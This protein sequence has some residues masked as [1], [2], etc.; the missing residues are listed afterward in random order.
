MIL[1]DCTQNEAEW[2]RL[3][4]GK[5]T[6]S[7]ADEILTPLFA[8]KTG[9]GP[10]TFLY[11]KVAEAYHGLPVAQFTSRAT[12][13]GHDLEDEARKWFLYLHDQHRMKTVGFCE[14][15]GKPCGCS[16]DALLD[17]DGGLEIKAPMAT[18]HVRYLI[19]GTLP[20]DYAVQVHFSMYVTGR[21]WW[22]FM[23]Y[24]RDFPQFVLKVHRDETIIGHIETAILAFSDQLSAALDRLRSLA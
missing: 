14:M 17:D 7:E 23:S 5:V 12:E 21:P 9:E 16:P 8:K 4:A 10:K 3:R 20:K 2:S 13:H 1:H 6:A 15:E 18:N 22:Y 24:H 19:D 11:R